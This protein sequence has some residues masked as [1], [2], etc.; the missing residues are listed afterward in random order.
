M[1]D[2]RQISLC[3]RLFTSH[4]TVVF[5][6]TV[7]GGL[8]HGP[9]AGS[10]SNVVLVREGERARLRFIGADQQHD[11]ACTPDYSAVV[12]SKNLSRNLRNNK[13]AMNT[14]SVFA[15]VQKSGEE[16][17]LTERGQFLSADVDGRITLSRPV[18]KAWERF[19]SR[20]DLS[21][22]LI[23]RIS[24]SPVHGAT[25]R[26]GD[27]GLLILQDGTAL[28]WHLLRWADARLNGARVK[29]TVVAK[30]AESCN[31]N[32]Y[33]HHW[34]G[35]DVCSIDMNGN[36][37]LN[38]GAEDIRVENRSDGFFAVTIIF[39]N[40]HPTLSFGTGK[41]R[42][43]YQGTGVD[44]YILQ[45][46]EVELLPLSPIRQILIDRIWR[47]CDP[48]RGLPANL[49]E[50][51]LQ[52][53]NSQHPYLGATIAAL[54]PAVIVEIGVWK[55]GST[56]FMANELKKN[57]LQS[58]VIVVDTWLGASDHWTGKFN[59]DL[60]FVNGYPALYYKFLANVIRAGVADF[61]LPLPIDSL[62]AAE[63]L[64]SHNVN[65]AMIHLDGG[66]DYESVMADLRVWWPLLTP[67]GILVGDDYF[68]SVIMFPKVRKAFDDFFGGLN[69][70]PIENTAGKCRVRK[71]T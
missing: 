17:G 49:F 50:Y 43:R 61:V 70:T 46:I 59:A 21:S 42:G 37:V 1:G 18:C 13:G 65:P 26:V 12:G 3:T 56:V 69:L 5:V 6:D 24:W 53:W 64:K 15:Y 8:R 45:N 51:D 9:L 44:Q 2:S 71:P 19:H 52:G 68:S 14:G 41:P 60:S 22:T 30:P 35:T 66:H 47:G 33:V 11:I 62:N 36:T 58:V 29:L 23:E 31:T 4:G 25:V 20:N 48:F 40:R 57:T 39:Q 32:L 55:G 7:S 63:I 38:E 28:D 34:G 54:R 67:G 27:D 10:P 16:F